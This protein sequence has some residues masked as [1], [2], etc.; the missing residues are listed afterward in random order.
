MIDAAGTTKYTYYAGGLLNTEDGP[1]S[2]DTV[3]YTYNN[4]LRASLSLQQ[5]TGTWNNGYTWDAAHRLSTE[6][7]PA[8]T[9]TYTYQSPGALVKKLALPNTSYI[10]NTYDSVARL[11]GTYLDN[12]SN[13]VLDKSENLYNT[14]NQR[15]RLTRT[16]GSY[17]TNSY[18]NIGQLV[19]ADSTVA[20]ED[21][22]YL[23]DAAWNLNKRTN[24]GAT[25]TFTVDTKNQLTNGPSGPFTYDT[26]GNLTS[27]AS[28]YISY[29][30]D[31]ENQLVTWGGLSSP[32]NDFSWRTDFVYDGRGRLRKRTESFYQS[33]AWGV[34]T[35]TRY[36]Y[37][38]M[39]VIQERNGF[40]NAPLVSYARG[41]DLSGNFEG[42]GGIG[43]LLAR[44]HAYQ[45]GSGSWTNHN[46]YHADGGGNITYMVNTN[47]SVVASYRYDPFGNTISSSGTLADANVYRFSSK[48]FHVNSGM[49]YYGYR[50]YDPN[51]QRWL[52]RD[53]LAEKG[54][55]AF[56]RACVQC[57]SS[58]CKELNVYRYCVNSPTLKYDAF[59]LDAEDCQEQLG[60]DMADIAKEG[61]KC[62][63]EATGT[64]L[65]GAFVSIIAV[66]VG[67]IATETPTGGYVAGGIVAVGWGAV[68]LCLYK[69][70]M[71]KVH[72]KEAAAKKRYDDCMKKAEDNEVQ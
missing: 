60:K 41:S 4:R 54:H 70:C 15:I 10:T 58:L 64:G 66:G 24:N 67:W 72:K 63:A 26:N 46:Y 29:L 40:N 36:V 42:A 9:F 23:Y 11:T 28:G 34:V 52:N 71:N 68:D 20:G 21:R 37:D 33:D 56:R 62:A 45:S 8:G 3:T 16:D 48:E 14:G 32:T 1:W 27:S 35:E 59:G 38:G 47:Q 44:S 61:A 50:F 13:T 49:Y 25:T 7:S 2:S 39:R 57:N 12:S 31:A 22:G 43:G 30:Y 65:A 51:L 17:Y 6:T 55:K 5:P 19:W 18:D 53:P 69:R